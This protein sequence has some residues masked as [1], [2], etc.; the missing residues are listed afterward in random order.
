MEHLYIYIFNCTCNQI[1]QYKLYTINRQKNLLGNDGCELIEKNF[2]RMV[3]D[4]F[5]NECKNRNKLRK[6]C[7]YTDEI[8]KF[9]LTLHFYSPKAYNYCR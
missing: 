4:L 6:G 9:A 2:N 1:V 5:E 3:G 7:R 8:K